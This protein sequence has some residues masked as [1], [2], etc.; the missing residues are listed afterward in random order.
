MGAAWFVSPFYPSDWHPFIARF[1]G[2]VRG[3]S[4]TN[5][6]PKL[7]S[8]PIFLY[9]HLYHARL[10]RCEAASFVGEIIVVSEV[11]LGYTTLG[12]LLAVLGQNIAR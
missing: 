6:A 8:H 12:L 5:R 7:G 9:R 10:W 1:I 11:I 2:C 4:I 3:S